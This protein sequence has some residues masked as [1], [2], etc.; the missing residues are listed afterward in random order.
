MLY[1]LNRIPTF[2][3]FPK[4]AAEKQTDLFSAVFCS[5]KSDYK[6]SRLCSIVFAEKQGYNKGAPSQENMNP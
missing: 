1:F 2:Y 5:R 4:K 3:R 6:R